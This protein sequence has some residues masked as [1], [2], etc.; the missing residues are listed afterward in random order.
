MKMSYVLVCGI[1]WPAM[2]IYYRTQAPLESTFSAS[3][4]GVPVGCRG[5]VHRERSP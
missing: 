5:T 1:V 3:I 2:H 4:F